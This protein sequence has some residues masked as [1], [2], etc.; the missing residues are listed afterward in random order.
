MK[1]LLVALNARYVHTNLAV[2]CLK[3]AVEEQKLE[4]TE[5]R[6][7][8]F[9]INDRLEHIAGEIFEEKPDLIGF[10]CYIWNITQILFLIRSLRL[11]LPQ[12]FL[13]AGG[14]EVSFDPQDLLS[15]VPQLDAVIAGEGEK[16]FPTLVKDLLQGRLPFGVKNL[17]WRS[18]ETG[19]IVS[20]KTEKGL[21]DLND[22]PSPYLQ[23]EDFHGRL[24]YVET[25]RGCPFSCEFCISSTT[26]GLR[27][28]EPEKFRHVIRHLFNNGAKTVKFV[29]RTFNANKKHAFAIL[30]VFREEAEKLRG[31]SEGIPRAHCEMAGDML[32][33]EW[34][35][36]LGS[37]PP[38]M[39]QVEIGVQSTHL[40]AL[41]AVNRRQKFSSW[42][43]KAKILQ[44]KFEIPVHLDLIAGLPG[45][46]W[47]EFRNSFNEVIQ[48]LPNKLQL[49]FLKVLKGSGVREKSTDFG[50]A[51]CPDPPYTILKTRELSHEEILSL[52][53]LEEILERYYN[54]GRF[55]YSIKYF[56]QNAASPFDFFHSFAVYW[57]KEGWFSLEW[58]AKALFGNLW[59]FLTGS[60]PPV[61][62]DATLHNR[63][64]WREIIR[65]DYFL[66]ERPGSIPE[67]LQGKKSGKE[68]DRIREQ[69]RK[70]A[71]WM[72]I[73]PDAGK[74]DRRQWARATSVEYFE[75]DHEYRQEPGL[76]YLFY[77]GKNGTRFFPYNEPEPSGLL[78]APKNKE[79]HL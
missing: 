42:K 57:Q 58:N 68:W 52:K 50:L 17:V 72:K 10:S 55:R 56:L 77:Y 16:S 2:R 70:D 21:P 79:R 29:D 26:H 39:I 8:E 18:G 5:V 43:E 35:A 7:R 25:S 53:R 40:P 76:W 71:G 37:L 54:S 75:V 30:N 31:Y 74:M 3:E 62:R 65:F 12:A 34:I 49:G 51:Y 27:Y 36:Y 41:R 44:H 61:M 59:Q 33:E 23:P 20:N 22:L 15:R 9:T 60:A 1:I 69:I 19:L 14:P 24:V 32:D 63:M 4:D 73:I 47:S 46:G 11:V 66:Q 38:G 67:F 6:I 28:L 78:I 13:L 48:V 45:E 64:I